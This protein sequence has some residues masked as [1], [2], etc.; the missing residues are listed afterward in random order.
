[1]KILSTIYECISYMKANS[2]EKEAK[3]YLQKYEQCLSKLFIFNFLIVLK[4]N[5]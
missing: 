5:V 1:M 2:E 4:F 3:L